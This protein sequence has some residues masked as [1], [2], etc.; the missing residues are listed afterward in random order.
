MGVAGIADARGF[1]AADFDLDGDID[2]AVNNY[3]APAALYIN[4][5]GSQ[6][7]W[8]AVRM[9][10]RGSNRDAIGAVL[11][12]KVGD[13]TMHRTVGSHAYSGQL[14]HE[15]LLGL[16]AAQAVDRLRVIWP[17]GEAEDFGS[18]P[19]G[20]RITLVQGRGTAVLPSIAAPPQEGGSV[21][22]LKALDYRH[23]ALGAFLCVVCL[24]S[25]VSLRHRRRGRENG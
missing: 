9:E 20:R 19:A 22:F 14:D 23:R 1:A 10:G 21:A 3:R 12:A 17:S 13:G 2:I 16:G 7:G 8:L 11:S 25:L 5:I 18:S 4:Q 15:V 24:G 6:S